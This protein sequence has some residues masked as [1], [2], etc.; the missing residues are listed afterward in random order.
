M[1]HDV[2]MLYGRT[3]TRL[4][5]LS[6][7]LVVCMCI[8]LYYAVYYLYI[9]L[10]LFSVNHITSGSIRTCHPPCANPSQSSIPPILHHIWLGG[11]FPPQ[12]NN[13]YMTCV[14]QHAGWK[15]VLWR[16]QD[17]LEFITEEYPWFLSTYTSYTRV[18][19]RAD[20]ARYFI[21]Y[22][23]GGVYVDMDIICNAPVTEI[24]RGTYNYS[25]VLLKGLP[26]GVGN[27]V[28]LAK[29]RHPL[30]CIAT[31][32]LMK[33]NHWYGINYL[34]VLFSTGPM[35][36]T[37]AAAENPRKEDLMLTELL[38]NKYFRHVGAAS[39]NSQYDLFFHV[40]GLTLR[41]LGDWGIVMIALVPILSLMVVGYV[42]KNKLS[43]VK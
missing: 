5:L 6:V 18:I 23:F 3:R 36:L 39:W 27:G 8:S 34:T 41:A 25:V 21:I 43:R 9:Y 19:Q 28:I 33:A 40:L 20:A 35:L 4:G 16:D 22:H 10:V 11:E 14:N 7:F 15:H 2:M 32:K 37:Q 17:V 29:P 26:R 13:T 42:F 38:N 31:Q 12:L 30:F 24:L 1:G